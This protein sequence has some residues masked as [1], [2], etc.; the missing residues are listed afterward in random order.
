MR[1]VVC[2]SRRWAI[3]TGPIVIGGRMLQHDK[4]TSRYPLQYGIPHCAFRIRTPHSFPAQGLHLAT[5]RSEYPD[6]RS[7]IERLGIAECGM[8]FADRGAWAI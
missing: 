5:P 4:Q 2:R 8:L 6:G 7:W 1:N 3:Q